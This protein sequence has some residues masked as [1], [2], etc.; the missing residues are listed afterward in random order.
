MGDFASINPATSQ[1]TSNFNSTSPQELA[2]KLTDVCL[3]QAN[4]KRQPAT[5]RASA[6]AKL[7][8]GLRMQKHDYGALITEEMGKPISEAVA[9]VEKCALACDYY[10]NHA[11]T[12]LANREIP[13]EAST[14]FVSFQPL[15][16]VLAIMPWNFPFWQ[17]FRCAAP[18]LAAGNALL[19][20][21]AANVCG[22][23]LA[24]EQ[25]CDSV[26]AL[27][28][29]VGTLLLSAED[30]SS[31]IEREEVAAVTFTGS[32]QAG[33]KVATQCGKHLKKC[34]LELGGSDPYIVLSDA[35]LDVAL[36]A[37]LTARMVNGGQ[38][39]IAA[40]R[41]IVTQN[42]YA[43]FCERF[44]HQMEAIAMG[45]PTDE[46]TRLGPLARR[47]LRDHLHQ[48]VLTSVAAGAKILTGG[49]V[50][51]RPGWYYPPTV[52]ADVR[53]D[54]PAF[55]EELFG[56]VAAIVCAKDDD[57][58]LQLANHST[59]G[60]GG[61]LFSRD[62][63]RATA[64]AR[65]ALQTGSAFVNTFVRSD[66]RLPFGGVKNSGYGRELGSYGILEFVNIKT[67]YVA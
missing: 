40:K 47:D 29:L 64:L 25:V 28:G 63:D 50:P 22:C 43:A 8:A 37:C 24:I 34:V 11:A 19:L 36:N 62:K 27:A 16:I 26:P 41:L 58:A 30:T 4:W 31:I 6:L 54:M 35:D 2:Q 20:K 52:L 1:L 5:V 42:H 59:F 17:F 32:T 51:K 44:T 39:C 38:S 61:A 21:H 10:A 18:A 66:P 56:P 23:A 12:F 46:A 15:G 7:A 67:V 33:S 45:D 60:L 9:E 13:T 53:P 65:D 49:Q 3:A 14:S 57:D 55:D 48:Q